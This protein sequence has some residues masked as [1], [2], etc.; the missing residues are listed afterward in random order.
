MTTPKTVLIADDDR[1]LVDVL[2]TRCREL[3]LKVLVAYD[4]RTA[5]HTVCQSHPNVICLDVMM[6]SGSGLSVCEMLVNDKELS[7]IPVIML[8]AKTDEETIRRC[9][10][11][12]AYYVPKSSNVWERL[13]PIL[14]ELLGVE[15]PVSHPPRIP[16]EPHAT[17]WWSELSCHGLSHL[18][19][20]I[21]Q[22]A[23]SVQATDG[24]DR[25]GAGLTGES[26]KDSTAAQSAG[27]PPDESAA[28]PSDH[29]KKARRRTILYIEDDVEA[30]N[31]MK[32][33]LESLDL[34]VIQAFNGTEGYRLA[35]A[36]TPDLVLCDYALPEGDGDYV[37]R[38][39]RENPVTEGI[40][41]VF[42]T[43]LPGNDLKRR[44]YGEGAAGYLTKPVSL[45]ELTQEL[46]AALDISIR[47]PQE[48]TSS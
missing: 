34:E 23:T 11:M 46:S 3:G 8:T 32:L 31:A 33:R 15:L 37:L 38:R 35:V 19:E 1:E 10:A 41:V 27:A 17:D 22:E 45:E 16:G 2:A 9:H 28:E 24:S 43:G 48:A 4:A 25:A 14:C 12:C 44:L 5:F 47:E 29:R 40:P 13:C 36:K 39:L 20:T 30:S 21:T 42:I 6:P 18:V 26:D 7:S